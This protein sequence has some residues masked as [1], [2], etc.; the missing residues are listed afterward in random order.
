MRNFIISISLFLISISQSVNAAFEI[1]AYDSFKLDNGLQ[2]YLMQQSEVPLIDIRLTVR[3]GAIHD[4]NNFGLANLA[5]ESL[6][7]GSAE[8]S[9]NEV[10]DRLAFHGANLSSNVS[11]EMTNIS[12]SIAA[13]D[14]STL[15]KLFRD[16]ALQPSFQEKEFNKLQTRY[17]S[18]LTQQRESP[19]NIIGDVFAKLYYEQHPYGNPVSG[20][21]QSV[22]KITLNQVK[23]FYQTHYTP[24]NSALIVVGDFNKSSTREQ[25]LELFGK[26]QGKKRHSSV[27]PIVK[28]KNSSNV[29]L[30]NKEDAIETT[31]II[32]GKGLPANHPE[33]VSAQVINTILGGRF[34]SWLNDEL[35]VNSGL[36]YG[37]RSRFNDN[38][39]AGSFIISTFTKK[40]TTFDALDLALKTYQRLWEK[41]IDKETLE[42]AKAYVK[43]QFPPRFETSGQLASLLSRM[44]ALNLNA[45]MINEFEK[46]VDSLDVT[47]ANKLAKSLFPRDNLQ[48]VLIGKSADLKEKAKRYGKIK[49]VDINKYHF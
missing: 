43:G 18:Q 3:A 36:T 32:G 27:L 37:A 31:F 39:M 38:S 29:L 28:N 47:K 46:K 44:W 1:P 30:L 48:Y 41:G 17:A 33:Y 15:F 8:L 35:R 16:V 6:M 40:E 20:D 4:Q 2:V 14:Q 9:K 34:T 12:M 5:G 45:S 25:I 19:R 11:R 22:S 24:Q 21:A 42:S 7:L 23:D 13:K 49:E 26:W 10:E